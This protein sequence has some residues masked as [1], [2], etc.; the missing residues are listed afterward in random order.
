MLPGNFDEWVTHLTTQE[1]PV[2]GSTLH[3]LNSLRD[4]PNVS[5]AQIAAVVLPDPMMTLKL[6]RIVNANKAGAFAQRI[7]TSEHAL[8]MLGLEPTFNRL[9]AVAVLEDTLSPEAQAGLL[10]VATRAYH[11]A[12]QARDWAVQRLDTAVEEVYIATLLQEV[13]E[14]ALWVAAPDKMSALEKLRNKKVN[15]QAEQEIFGFVIDKLSAALVEQWNMPPLVTT[16]TQPEQCEAHVRPRCIML[17]KRLARDAEWGWYNPALAED[18]DVIAEARRIPRDEV[19]AQV[20]RTAANAGRRC[21]FGAAQPAATWL[22]MLP[23]DWPEEP[24]NVVGEPV[25]PFQ[26]AM[27][28]IARHLDGTLTLHELLVLVMRGMR[29]GVGLERIVFALLSNDRA[30]L[31]ARAVVGAEEN[32]PIKAFR[33]NMADKHLFSVLMAKPQAIHLTADNRVKYAA[34]LTEDIV[35]TTSGRDFCAMSI[36]LHGKVIGMFYG[37]GGVVDASHYEKFKKLCAQASLGMAHLAK[38]A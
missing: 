9:G 22:P 3:E 5:G 18:F 37:D 7:A 16:A 24:S 31:S 27:D 14:M 25:D 8:M 29:N 33:F 23:G 2:L 10:Q 15:V 34:Y 11:A 20:H 4:K 6:M 12:M 13:G 21:V 19:I 17:A 35:K 28:E 1:L 36:S 26:I 32:A 38:K 30:T